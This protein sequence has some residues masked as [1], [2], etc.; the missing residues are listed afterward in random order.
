MSEQPDM[1]TDKPTHCWRD[2]R[3]NAT[4]P[5]GKP[6]PCPDHPSEQIK[7]PM[8]TEGSIE[9]GHCE[10]CGGV[11]ADDILLYIRTRWRDG[12]FRAR[13]TEHWLGRDGAV[14]FGATVS[15]TVIVCVADDGA[16][17]TLSAGGCND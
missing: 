11:I 10:V 4:E 14:T 6:L 8:M 17:S 9:S 3:P 5:C 13:H 2:I 15:L 1:M 12:E 16:V 7:E